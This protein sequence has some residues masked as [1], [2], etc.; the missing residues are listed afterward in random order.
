MRLR[1]DDVVSTDAERA[2]LAAL[3]DA[4][5]AT[6]GPM[7][8]HALRVFLVAERLGAELGGPFDREVVLCASLLH[9]VGAYP[10]ASTGGVYVTDGRLF[11]ERT[12]TPFA[13]SSER[14]RVCLDAV[15]HHHELRRQWARG[16]EVELIRRADLVDV[17]PG[18]ITFGLRRPWLRGLALAVP[19]RGIYGEVARIIG[20]LLRERPTTIPRIFFPRSGDGAA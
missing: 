11:A 18:L 14:L 6:D 16:A 10:L 19:R 2:C 8:R 17:L 3:R 13:W 12:L 4:T 15:E 20:R 5:R 1:A 7:E 9:D